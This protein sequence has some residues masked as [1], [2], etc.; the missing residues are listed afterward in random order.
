MK[1]FLVSCLLLSSPLTFAQD[2][3]EA[4]ADKATIVS[5]ETVEVPIAKDSLIEFDDMDTPGVGEII[6]YAKDL[7]ALGESVYDLVQKG[8]PVI[9]HSFSPI[10]VVPKVNGRYVDPFD[11][12]ETSNAIKKK[13]I[14]S[15]RNMFKQEV[16]RF[17]YMVIFYIGKF[18]GKGRYIQNAA[19]I[20][21]SSKALFG[22]D[23]QSQMR[24]IGISNKGTKANPVAS[25]V[26]NVS[27]Q[28]GSVLKQFKYNDTFTISG[29]GSI[30]KE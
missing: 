6:G 17:E 14:V 27:Y 8:K 10:N 18:E 9:R 7:V 28:M 19:I 30:I 23:L 26:L 3:D 22:F 21:Q 2:S 20:P 1:C 12:E 11:L 13:Y 25:A 29:K 16:V 15:A 24:L 4:F 5:I